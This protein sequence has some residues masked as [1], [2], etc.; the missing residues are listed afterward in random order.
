MHWCKYGDIE[1]HYNKDILR[2]LEESDLLYVDAVATLK[3]DGPNVSFAYDGEDYR[4]AKRTSL[5][6]DD[7][8]FYNMNKF[9]NMYEPNIK[10]MY[11]YVVNKNNTIDTLIIFGEVFGG[12]YNHKTINRINNASKVQGR[13]SYSPDNHVIIYDIMTVGYNPADT[14][15][16]D[17]KYLNWDEVKGLCEM[18]N[19]MVVPEIARGKFYDL[20]KMDIENINDPLHNIIDIN[21][22]IIENNNIEGIVIKPLEEKQFYNEKRVICKLKSTKFVEKSSVPKVKID[23]DTKIDSMPDEYKDTLNRL[24]EYI[25]PSRYFS[26][27]SKIGDVESKDFGLIMKSYYDDFIS[28]FKKDYPEDLYFSNIAEKEYLKIINKVINGYI[29]QIVKDILIYGKDESELN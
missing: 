8:N 4:I 12:Y 14:K 6:D 1:N 22:P 25:T 21:L 24:L 7:A 26:V 9:K 20:M 11:D 29:S 2:Y 18:F 17:V 23:T 28:E 19:F 10:E 3:V 15:Y 5:I 13:I 16:F 27:V